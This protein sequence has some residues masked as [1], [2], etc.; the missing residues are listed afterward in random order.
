MRGVG[1]ALRVEGEGGHGIVISIGSAEILVGGHEDNEGG[2]ERVRAQ[3]HDS[4]SVLSLPHCLLS[5]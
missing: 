4:P 3:K 2:K 1:R 5:H